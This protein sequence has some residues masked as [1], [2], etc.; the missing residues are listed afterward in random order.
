MRKYGEEE[1]KLEDEED[2]RPCFA[3]TFPSRAVLPLS[4]FPSPV[5]GVCPG[6]KLTPSRTSIQSFL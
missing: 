3:E 5:A 2:E 1:E 6:Q 4:A